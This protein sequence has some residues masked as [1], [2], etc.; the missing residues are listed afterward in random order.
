MTTDA[1]SKLTEIDVAS[2]VE[3]LLS[4]NKLSH[5]LLEELSTK[6]AEQASKQTELEKE[7]NA[8]Q[9]FCR[10]F[11]QKADFGKVVGELEKCVAVVTDKFDTMNK[12]YYIDRQKQEEVKVSVRQ[13]AGTV[14]EIDTSLRK[15]I[16]ELHTE[17]I[18]RANR[19]ERAS[20]FGIDDS[21]GEQ[22]AERIRSTVKRIDKVATNVKVQPEAKFDAS[23]VYEEAD[24]GRRKTRSEALPNHSVNRRSLSNSSS[25]GRRSSGSQSESDREKPKKF[26]IPAQFKSCDGSNPSDFLDWLAKI[27]RAASASRW[28]NKYKCWLVANLVEGRAAQTLDSC[29]SDVKHSWKE[30]RRKLVKRLISPQHFEHMRNELRR[31]HQKSSEDVYVYINEF[32]DKAR[33]AYANDTSGKYEE[34]LIRMFVSGLTSESLRLKTLERECDNLD[35]A[36]EYVLNVVTLQELA[37]QKTVKLSSPGFQSTPVPTKPCDEPMPNQIPPGANVRQSQRLPLD[38]CR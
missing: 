35:E 2:A 32:R 36:S 7:L 34:E 31:L 6:L 37:R 16:N 20:P 4:D 28:S 11:I 24:R 5:G 25:R 1:G 23:S 10:Q 15:G 12:D 17:L 18:A 9:V 38:L 19:S 8:T 27:E 26:K 21:D 22:N 29:S 13:L 3:K 33:K 30:L 14:D